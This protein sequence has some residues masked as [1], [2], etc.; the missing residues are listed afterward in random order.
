MERMNETICP[1]LLK[2]FIGAE[3]KSYR[4]DPIH[5]VNSVFEIIGIYIGDRIYALTNKLEDKEY[6]SSLEPI[7]VLRLKEVSDVRSSLENTVQIEVP[8]KSQISAIKLVNEHQLIFKDDKLDFEGWITRA[9]IF[10]LKNEQEIMFEKESWVY[11]DRII[12]Y[13]GANIISKLSDPND[14]KEGWEDFNLKAE[15]ER[16]VIEIA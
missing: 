10:I 4:H 11:S 5:L 12:P 9:V 8:V 6:Y 15:C 1:E 14:F 7:S 13:K 16:K 3:F 2:S